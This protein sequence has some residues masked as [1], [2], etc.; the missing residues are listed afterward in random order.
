MYNC[1]KSIESGSKNKQ[2][3][4]RCLHAIFLSLYVFRFVFAYCLAFYSLLLLKHFVI[5]ISL[6]CKDVL[7][8]LALLYSAAMISHK[9]LSFLQNESA[10]FPLCLQISD[11]SQSSLLVSAK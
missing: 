11:R 9:S 5:L 7:F 10:A 6:T 8:I 1:L 3:F 4:S 2:G